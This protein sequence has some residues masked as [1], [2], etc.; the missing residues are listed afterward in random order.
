MTQS[1]KRNSLCLRVCLYTLS[2]K[3]LEDNLYIEIFLLWLATALKYADLDEHDMIHLITDKDTVEY[4]ETK[5]YF[6]M[7]KNKLKCPI[8]KFCL[9]RPTTN[10]EGM[11]YKYIFTDYT[12]DVFMYCDI[13]ILIIK[14]IHTIIESIHEQTILLHH[15]GSICDPDYGGAFSQEDLAGI[16]EHNP[17]FSAGKFIICGKELHKKFFKDIY[18]LYLKNK[19]TFYYTFEQP[20]FNKVIYDLDITTVRLDI[21]DENFISTN[22]TVTPSCILMDHCGEPA[23]GKLHYTKMVDSVVLLYAGVL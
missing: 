18:D 11:M 2:E 19:N 13:D 9:P 4:L 17:G 3:K 20:Y 15:E 10:L 7:L 21:L 12:Q 23:D 16:P 1:K 6:F 8:T 14:S 22:N 5:T